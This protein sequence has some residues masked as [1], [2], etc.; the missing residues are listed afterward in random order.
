MSTPQP[1]AADSLEWVQIGALDAIPQLGSRVVRHPDGDIAVF[2]NRQDEVFAL[3]DRCPHRGGPLSQ[4]IVCDRKVYCPLH[5]MGIALDTGQAI[6]PDEGET[7]AF[8]TRVDEG[9]V[10]IGLPVSEETI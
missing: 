7:T 9:M 1:P 5:N 3:R 10:F 2:R 6:A 8:P 4:G